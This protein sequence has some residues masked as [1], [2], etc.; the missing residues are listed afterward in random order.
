MSDLPRWSLPDGRIVK[1]GNLLDDA[2]F[3][4]A[5]SVRWQGVP[6][7]PD[8]EL[9]PFDLTHDLGF[10]IRVR[11]QGQYGA[12]N[13]HAAASTLELARWIHGYRHVELS[14]WFIYAIL[15][16][17]QDQG[18]II[19]EAVNLLIT[20]GTCR[21]GLVPWGTIDPRRLTTEAKA[22]AT[23]YRVEIT[24]G[25]LRSFRDL[26]IATAL[27]WP[28]N[29]SVPVNGSFNTLD[30]EGVPGN[31]A[32]VHNHAVAGGF[33]LLKSARRGWLVKTLNSWST[34][35]GQKGYFNAA[36][37]TLAGT[38]ADSYCICA[39]KVLSDE[40]PPKIEG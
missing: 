13:G 4:F 30:A 14:P 28:S 2:P 7:I 29:Y 36:E 5:P 34:G 10:P 33:G 40:N 11:D 17:G 39:V 8:S 9:I 22:D 35:W 23:R 25:K 32:G 6:D 15:C 12:C 31:R 21:D 24:L 3:S 37:K 18:S 20:Q 19:S 38:W 16:N 26:V 27:R 1:L